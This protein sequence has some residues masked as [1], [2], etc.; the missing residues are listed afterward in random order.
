MTHYRRK[1]EVASMRAS[2]PFQRQPSNGYVS[3]DGADIN[4]RFEPRN[5]AQRLAWEAYW[6]NDVLFF[7]GASGGGK[8]A[9]AIGLALADLAAGRAK[10][11]VVT[12]PMVEAG[13]ELGILPGDVSDKVRP[14]VAP[15]ED[16]LAGQV[17]PAEL[18]KLMRQV[19]FVPVAVIRGRT[20]ADTVV[21]ADE[22]QNATPTQM[23]LV[24]SR[25]GR[26]SRGCVS[27]LVVTGDPSQVDLPHGKSGLVWA[28]ERLEGL[29]G[30]GVVRFRPDDNL[31]HG[32]VSAMMERLVD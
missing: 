20:F 29:A 30:V 6:Q 5:E 14:W 28:V 13:E 17:T 18:R 1:K 27:K 32:L 7:L 22:M 21:V 9:A 19:E 31:R 12:R 2:I 15:V 11:V 8:T 16:A 26:A 23:R 24:L 10:R 25:L 3:Q 4:F